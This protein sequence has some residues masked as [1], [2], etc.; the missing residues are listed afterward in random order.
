MNL[1]G[2]RTVLRTYVHENV[3]NKADEALLLGCKASSYLKFVPLVGE[4]LVKVDHPMCIGRWTFGIHKFPSVDL[5]RVEF[6]HV[7][8]LY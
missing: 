1:N 6:A 3:T 2:P 8:V 5:G 7:E 4:E